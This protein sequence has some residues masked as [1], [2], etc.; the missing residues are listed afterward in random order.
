MTA[1]ASIGR[2]LREAVRRAELRRDGVLPLEPRDLEREQLEDSL[3]ELVERLRQERAASRDL[4]PTA[5]RNVV[6]LP[7]NKT[8]PEPRLRPGA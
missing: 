2:A 1:G 5:T 8:A 7:Q 3:L 6:A 4:Y